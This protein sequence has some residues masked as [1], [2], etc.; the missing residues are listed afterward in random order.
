[1]ALVHAVVGARPC[2]ELRGLVIGG[3][4][5]RALIGLQVR[6]ARVLRDGVE[7]EVAIEFAVSWNP[8]VKSK[9]SAVTTTITRTMSSPIPRPG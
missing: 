9:P 7:T 2:R 6:T 3:E 4:A 1:M 8:L 5:I